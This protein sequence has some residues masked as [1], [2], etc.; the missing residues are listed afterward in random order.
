VPRLLEKVYERIISKGLELKGAKRSLFFWAVRLGEKWENG[1][2]MGFW[3]DLQ[4]KI[5]RKLSSASGWSSCGNVFAICSGSAPLNAKI[6]KVFT[7]A[8]IV[9]MEGYGLTETSPVVSVNRYN[10]DDNILGSVGPLVPNVEV[11]IA[12]DGEILTRGPN[13][14]KGYYKLPDET[15]KA[16]DKDGWFPYR[17]HW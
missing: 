1:K 6:W 9:I 15:A 12:E 8:G 17:R 4:I 14:M 2:N 3:Y 11:K 7:A 10:L 5:A 13:I 16:I